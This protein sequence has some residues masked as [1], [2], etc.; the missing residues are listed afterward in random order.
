[1]LAIASEDATKIPRRE[2]REEEGDD[3]PNRG[4]THGDLVATGVLLR[5]AATLRRDT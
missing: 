2:E 3:D 4:T 5:G 1:V